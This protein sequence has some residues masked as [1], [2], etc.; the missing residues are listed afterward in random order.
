[1][2]TLLDILR[3]AGEPTR[4]R[5]LAVLARGELTVTELT[6]VLGQSQ[7]RV[8]RHLKLMVDAGLL[9]RKP[10]GS[11]AFFRLAGE[12]GGR[13][14]G[15]ARRLTALLTTLIPDKDADLARDLQRLE[16][17]KAARAKAAQGYFRANAHAWNRLRSLYVAEDLV[18]RAIQDLVGPGPFAHLV[19]IGTGTGRML[20]LL[21][22][23]VRRA[24][25]LD[26]S[27]EMLTLARTLLDRARLDHVQV[28]HGD[29]FALPYA[30]R[31]AGKGRAASDVDLVIIHQVLH[32]LTDPAGAVAEAARI[33]APGG[34]LLVVDFAPHGIEELRARHAHRRLGFSEAEVSALLE[35]AGLEVE[36]VRHLKP[37]AEDE[38]GEERLTVTLWLAHA[39]QGARQKPLLQAAS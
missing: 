4:L 31:G 12:T 17:V 32:Y 9:E 18:E 3:A 37:E 25:G 29:L 34:R 6:Q 28:R 36:E 1:M 7:P 30:S 33:L 38:E 2:Q 39:P 23:R 8:S 11:W 19:D 16:T 26:S 35:G 14:A 22:P 27:H 5:I 13:A 21:A 15:D 10:E 24:E 20:E